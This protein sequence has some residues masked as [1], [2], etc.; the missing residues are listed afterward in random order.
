MYMHARTG[1]C[2]SLNRCRSELQL[3]LSLRHGRQAGDLR[4]GCHAGTSGP[5][6]WRETA[7]GLRGHANGTEAGGACVPLYPP[8]VALILW[9]W[10]VPVCDCSAPGFGPTPWRKCCAGSREA[11]AAAT[12][13]PVGDGR[14]DHRRRDAA[15]APEG[16]PPH[17]ACCVAHARAR[18][19]VRAPRLRPR[20]PRPGAPVP[21]LWP[22]TACVCC[23]CVL[24]AFVAAPCQV[25][26]QPVTGCSRGAGCLPRQPWP[27]RC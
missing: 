26:V 2:R 20:S 9:L 23:A 27:S 13:E 18:R 15:D 24:C 8:R 4:P 12:H 17:Q 21:P 11:A 22:H 16:H 5:G 25:G 6:T 10:R 7:S 19:P 14:A 3:H 1:V